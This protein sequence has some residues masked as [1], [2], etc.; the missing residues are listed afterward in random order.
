[1][2]PAYQPDA[3]EAV[4]EAV[5][6]ELAQALTIAGKQERETRTDEIKAS[7]LEKLGERFVGRESELGNAF[8]ALNKK[9][10][11]RRILT[12]QVRIDGR[13]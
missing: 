4:S 2:F 10:V 9:L 8:R 13:A 6:Q 7:V 5:E 1:M 12:D 3:F 11:R